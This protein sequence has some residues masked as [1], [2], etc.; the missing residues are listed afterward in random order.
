VVSVLRQRNFALLF[1]AGVISM[2]GDWALWVALPITVFQLTHSTVA[3]GAT[4]LSELIPL[5][6]LSSVGG[7]FADRWDRK[8]LMIVCD[9]VLAVGLL[10][11]LLV[12]S[13]RLVWI[14]YVVALLQSIVVRFFSPAESAMLPTVVD[15]EHLVTANS[16]NSVGSETARLVGPAIGGVIAVSTGLV[17]VTLID[18]AS[19]LA[20]AGL[21]SLVRVPHA[22]ATVN[23]TEEA[24]AAWRKVWREWLDGLAVVRRSRTIALFLGVWAIT[25][26]GEAVMGIMFVVWV[27]NVVHGGALQL[28]WFMSA[29]AVGGV[30]GGLA[31]AS[32]GRRMPMILMAWLAPLFFGAGDILLF[33]YPLV[34]SQ[35]WVGL[36]LIAIVG[37][38]ASAI[39]ATWTTLI[40]T[41]VED[42]L[43]G[44]VFGALGTTQGLMMVFGT[45][46]AGLFGG[47][48]S[49][50]LFLN[51]AQGGGY[52]L[53][54]VLLFV[55]IGVPAALL[56]RRRA[57]GRQSF[58]AAGSD[59][60]R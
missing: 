6:L 48:I 57:S 26:F 59:R 43:R 41:N 49:P 36:A 53:V 39:G 11:L 24:V 8:R 27:K 47:A 5:L 9:L 25:G 13:A 30:L 10:P 42:D 20:A 34:T 46:A 14:V 37:L 15:K 52:L 16:L 51:V 56:N 60:M 2:V 33:S 45:A 29:Q 35:L 1:V 17:G 3:M 23:V 7:V 44:R 31:I 32:L 22:A 58:E 4:A 50:I 40:Q 54:G 19:F 12:H 38:P 55:T 18:A 21:I 28:G